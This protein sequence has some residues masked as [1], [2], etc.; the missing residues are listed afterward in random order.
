ALAGPGPHARYHTLYGMLMARAT[1]AVLVA[2]AP[3]RRPFVL[4]SA[5]FIGGQREAAAWTGDNQAAWPHLAASVPMVLNLGMSGQPF[6]GPDIGGFAG[7]GDPGLF[8]RWMGFG[9][10]FPFARGHSEKG[11]IRKEPWAF[12]RGVEATCRRA[13]A[14]RYR[15]LPYL[16]TV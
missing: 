11:T 12:G 8:A 14:T 6:A 10:L 9:A 13:I 5:N 15:L 16:Y 2:A 1:R 3:D 7:A 4:S